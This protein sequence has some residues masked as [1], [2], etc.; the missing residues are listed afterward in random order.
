MKIYVNVTAFLNVVFHVSVD[1]YWREGATWKLHI[2]NITT[3]YSRRKDR[4][5][6]FV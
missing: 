4:E 6:I 5:I 1:G 3:I 2:Y